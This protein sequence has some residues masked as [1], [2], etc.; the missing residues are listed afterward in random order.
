MG[1]QSQQSSDGL[2]GEARAKA[3]D[4]NNVSAEMMRRDFLK[5]AGA[6]AGGSAAVGWQSSATANVVQT[7]SDPTPQV[8]AIE[9]TINDRTVRVQVDTRTTLLDLLREQLRLTG[10]KKGCDQGACGACTVLLDG[11]RVLACLTLAVTLDGKQVVTIEGLAKNEDL[12]PLQQ[13][14]LRCDAYQC[15]YC[16]PGQIM[17]GVG[18]IQEGRVNQSVEETREWMSGNLCRCSAYPN[19]VAAVR[20]AAGVEDPADPTLLV[21]RFDSSLEGRDR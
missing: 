11:Q 13:A 4:S 6:I 8:T 21:T 15:G 12:H 5:E 19:I 9:L 17:S 16:T 18:C 1:N 3:N 20:Q 14:F 10:T 2:D 7:Q